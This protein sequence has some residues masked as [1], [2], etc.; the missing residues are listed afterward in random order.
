MVYIMSYVPEKRG[1][2]IE[3]I[4]EPIRLDGVKISLRHDGKKYK[5]VCFAPG[6]EK[7]GFETNSDY[8]KTDSFSVENGY[9]VIVFEE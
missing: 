2:M 5:S 8:I 6:K 3:M 9:A 4:E 7:L 1:E